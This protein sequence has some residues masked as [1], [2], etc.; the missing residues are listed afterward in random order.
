MVSDYIH[1]ALYVTSVRHASIGPAII[2]AMAKD[3][4]LTCEGLTK[5]FSAAPLFEGLSFTLF[6]GDHVGLVGPNGAGKSTLMK[7]LAGLETSDSGTLALRKGVRV[8]YVHQDPSFPEGLTAEDA[9]LHSMESEPGL[10]EY[11]RFQRVALALGK[12]GFDDRDV[13]VDTLSGG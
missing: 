11:E 10:E 3:V 1:R 2:A 5:A 13:R 7:I 8:G 6:A 4:L 12:A 9:L